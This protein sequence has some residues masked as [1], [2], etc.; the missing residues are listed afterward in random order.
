MK[1]NT[2]HPYL[3]IADKLRKKVQPYFAFVSGGEFDNRTSEIITVLI[4][5]DQSI[6]HKIHFLAN[7]QKAKRSSNIEETLLFDPNFKFLSA[8]LSNKAPK[9]EEP[10]IDDRNSY[11]TIKDV[12]DFLTMNDKSK[13]QE[14]YWKN[15]LL[16]IKASISKIFNLETV[17]QK[18]FFWL[19]SDE[20]R[21]RYSGSKLNLKNEQRVKVIDSSAILFQGQEGRSI[22]LLTGVTYSDDKYLYIGAKWKLKRLNSKSKEKADTTG[23]DGHKTFKYKSVKPSTEEI[24]KATKLPF[25]KIKGQVYT[26]KKQGETFSFYDEQGEIKISHPDLLLYLLD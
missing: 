6:I 21:P 4:K 20:L 22:D 11:S 17:P 3:T 9:F 25:L 13:G 8:A 23:F 5:K 16:G 10:E 2:K 19:G 15:H 1:K 7:A 24:R 18:E 12:V 26:L 14:V